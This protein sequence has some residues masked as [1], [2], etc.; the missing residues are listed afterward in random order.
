[1][2]THIR[3]LFDTPIQLFPKTSISCRETVTRVLSSQYPTSLPP[4]SLNKRIVS[5]ESLSKDRGVHEE[6]KSKTQK[7]KKVCASG[8]IENTE[9]TESVYEWNRLPVD[10]MQHMQPANTIMR[11]ERENKIGN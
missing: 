5:D 6:K 4:E 10:R 9:N 3:R 1:M 2:Y 11:T 8:K 7:I